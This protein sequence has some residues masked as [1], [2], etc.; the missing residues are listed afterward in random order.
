MHGG[1]RCSCDRGGPAVL[2]VALPVEPA[3]PAF[4]RCPEDEAALVDAPRVGA[5]GLERS[6][7]CHMSG[8]SSG[9]GW[10]TSNS[11]RT[12][13]QLLAPPAALISS[14]AAGS[15]LYSSNT[16]CV[17]AFGPLSNSFSA[18]A[19]SFTVGIASGVYTW[20]DRAL[21]PYKG[22]RK[23]SFVSYH[24]RAISMN[25]VR[26][27]HGRCTTPRKKLRAA[28]AANAPAAPPRLADL[29]QQSV[30]PESK[31]RA[32]GYPV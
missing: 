23:I 19:N 11:A 6:D 28:S 20:R 3:L 18:A 9:C 21:T 32:R 14:R 26:Q 7:T 10:Y 12:E 29:I 13:S 24:T 1:A 5:G 2:A 27:R 4:A 16:N 15:A 8:C 25:I 17:M 30:A 22:D 31:C